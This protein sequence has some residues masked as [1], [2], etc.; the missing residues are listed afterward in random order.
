MTSAEINTTNGQ[1]MRWVLITFLVL[2]I[3]VAVWLIRDIL[4]LTLTAV[5]F[6]VLLTTPIRFFVRRGIRR[7]IAILLTIILIVAV[8]ALTTAL[9][10]PDLLKQ[11]RDLAHIIQDATRQ[12]QEELRTDKL[13][14]RFPFLEGLDLKNIT[15]QIST[16]FLGGLTNVTREV[17]PFV[18]SLAS[19]LL[20]VLIV[21]FLG[22]YFVSDPG[23]HERGL[24]KLV[25]LRYRPRANE[26]LI[27]LDK[28]L[29][30]F[31][32]GQLVLMVLTGVSTGAGLAIIGV[33]FAGALGI[34]TGLFSFVPNFGPLVSLIPIL[35]VAIV[36]TPDKIGLIIVVFYVLQFILGSLITPLLLGQEINLPPAIILLSQI[37]A[38]IFFGFLG[39]LLAVPLAAILVLLIREIYIKDILGDVEYDDRPMELD[40][41]PDGV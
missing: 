25:P 41:H 28:V 27:K 32:Q 13:T 6:S 4:M 35:A 21:V 3:A 39:L 22:V 26:I 1:I 31:L 12:L 33:P 38:G 34:I 14:T 15:D 23:M 40:M 17:F 29:R 2:L 19:T 9:L 16:Q 10:L 20:S 8:I 36:N 11:F 24:I 5:I 37:I 18:G 7:P 30:G